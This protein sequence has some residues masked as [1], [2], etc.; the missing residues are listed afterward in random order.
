MLVN[1]IR[2]S[3]ACRRKFMGNR[4]FGTILSITLS[5]RVF[6]TTAFAD[7]YHYDKLNRVSEIV[8]DDGSSVHYA[9]DANGNLTDIQKKEAPGA[10]G[11]DPGEN[12]GKPGTDNPGEEPEKPGK[13]EPEKGP[14]KPGGQD[15]GGKQEGTESGQNPQ[16]EEP[17][18]GKPAATSESSI[19]S[20]PAGTRIETGTIRYEITENRKEYAVKVTGLKKKT[21][22][23]KIPDT[24]TYRNRKYPVTEIADSAFKGQK[25]LKKVTIGKHIKKIGKNAFYGASAL[26]KI[27]VKTTE[28]KKVGKNAFQG[29]HPK[30]VIKVPKKKL[31]A[32]RKLFAQKGQK[33]TVK[34]KK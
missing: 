6:S 22:S 4:I 34:I 30:A 29:I 14:D 3:I 9:Y 33:D 10:A 25:K 12:P 7:T 31:E 19:N 24:V 18:K 26:K 11:T 32:Y 5:L 21:K 17:E 20:A 23:L 8:Y 13:E 16:K 27:T 2:M 1:Y 15:S 28:L